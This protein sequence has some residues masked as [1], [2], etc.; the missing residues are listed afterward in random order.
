L[1]AILL[2]NILFTGLKKQ[3]L[4]IDSS[5]TS[6]AEPVNN[7]VK[8]IY[9]NREAVVEL[10]LHFPKIKPGFLVLKGEDALPMYMAHFKYHQVQGAE[11]AATK[12]NL[13][14]VPVSKELKNCRNLCSWHQF[15]WVKQPFWDLQNNQSES[16]CWKTRRL[17][18]R[19][20]CR[21]DYTEF[22]EFSQSE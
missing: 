10:D 2:S 16:P 14:L 3:E 12:E 6:I 9:V 17:R 1:G 22:D 18:K 20:G 8:P 7:M 4:L 13:D 15:C 5:H 19:L 21:K 11:S